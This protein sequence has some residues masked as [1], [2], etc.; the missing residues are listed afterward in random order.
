M[1]TGCSAF[2]ILDV[3]GSQPGTSWPTF[4][5]LYLMAGYDKKLK[6]EQRHA[7]R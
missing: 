4:I 3:V 6:Q 7:I 1:I 5:R 2:V